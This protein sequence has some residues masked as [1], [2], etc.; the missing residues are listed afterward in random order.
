MEQL[1]IKI[2]RN[3]QGKIFWQEYSLDFQ[4]GKSVF[5][6]LKY[7]QEKLDH[8]LAFECSCNAGLCGACALRVNERAVLSCKELVHTNT[9]LVIRALANLPIVKDLVIDWRKVDNKMR[10]H[11][12]WLFVDYEPLSSDYLLDAEATAL[13]KQ[14]AACISCGICVSVCPVMRQDGFDYPFV[15]CKGQRLVMDPNVPKSLRDA[16]SADLSAKADKC[17]NCK[18]C[19]RHCPKSVSPS[20]SVCEFRK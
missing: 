6:Y 5:W 7:I 17:I 9:T 19:D 10:E 13:D 2:E 20:S 18:A 16:V 11:T 14:L 3:V 4:A 1:L 15:F 12:K 8:T